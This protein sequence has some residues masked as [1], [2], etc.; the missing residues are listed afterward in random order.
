[1]SGGGG[2]RQDKADMHELAITENIVE[3]AVNASKG[4][5]VKEINLVLGEL[6]GVVQESIEFCFTFVSRGTA[7]EGAKISFVRV[8]AV[9][10][11]TQCSSEH[12]LNE[13][14]RTCIECGSSA[15]E[16]I[17]GRE[18]YIES[19][20]VEEDDEDQGSEERD[21]CERPGGRG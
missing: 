2:R 7:S 19:I 6:S 21:G 11:C 12:P 18:F 5:R 10:G 1:M 14:N 3:I 15:G 17:R 20:E 4:C 16:I 13:G 8:P 9:V